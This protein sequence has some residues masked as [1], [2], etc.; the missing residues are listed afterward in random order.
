VTNQARA[1]RRLFS[2]WGWGGADHAVHVDPRVEREFRGLAKLEAGPDDVLLFHYSAYAPKLLEQLERPQRKVLVSHNIT[3]ARWFWGHEPVTAV[4]CAIGREQLPRFASSVDLALGV[5]QYNADELAV[6]GARRT[7]VVPILVDRARLGHA[8]AEYLGEQPRWLFVGRLVPHKRP[9]LLIR[10]LALY[11]AEHGVDARLKWV[12]EPISVSYLNELRAFAEAVAPGAVDFESGLSSEDL[13][14]RWKAADVFVCASEHEGFCIPLL[15][16]FHFGVPVVARSFGGIPE[17]AGDAALLLAPDDGL[18]VLVEA[19][20]LAWSDP[21][22]RVVMRR[23]S[24]QRLDA[25]A[26]DVTAAKLRAAL[27]S[28]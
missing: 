1:Y 13:A 11:R 26:F 17:V 7:G 23:R 9:D 21:S 24:A 27:E 2:E 19:A 25:F 5:S 3:P 15:E 12:G 16:A 8:G 18:P 6:A 28:V 10:A 4:H 14:A 20:H 22:V